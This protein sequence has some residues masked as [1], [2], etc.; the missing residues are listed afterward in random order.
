MCV[1]VLIGEKCCS[2][3]PMNMADDEN[4]TKKMKPLRS[5]R[6]EHVENTKGG[7]CEWGG[8]KWLFLGCQRSILVRIGMILGAIV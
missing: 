8:L 1:C 6:N 4:F 5:L 3:I 7:D 2:Y